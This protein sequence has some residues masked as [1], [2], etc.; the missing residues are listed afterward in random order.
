MGGGA[1]RRSAP[2]SRRRAG[3][4]GFAAKPRRV[5][6][7]AAVSCPRP[8]ARDRLSAYRCRAD[9]SVP[10]CPRKPHSVFPAETL[11]FQRPS[12]SVARRRHE[13]RKKK[14]RGKRRVRASG[15]EVRRVEAPRAEPRLRAA[16]TAAAGSGCGG[17]AEGGRQRRRRGEARRKRGVARRRSYGSML[18][19]IL[20]WS[21]LG[22][23]KKRAGEGGG[24]M[25]SSS[26]GVG[27]KGKS[28]ERERGEKKRIVL[29]VEFARRK[30][31][32]RSAE[33]RAAQRG[34][35]GATATRSRGETPRS[36]AGRD[37]PRSATDRGDAPRVVPRSRDGPARVARHG[38]R[39]ALT[40]RRCPRRC[41]QAPGCP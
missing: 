9:G 26:R 28:N 21:G 35:P 4:C 36:V 40:R 32:Q 41:A 19:R 14:A 39:A 25:R 23:E 15:S 6:P 33:A 18:G 10:V 34:R 12:K 29:A 31:G 27:E 24:E 7:G 16:M 2:G 11:A 1:G 3:A 30:V 5:G 17:W 37:A 38:P 8:G 22:K 13:K 20:L